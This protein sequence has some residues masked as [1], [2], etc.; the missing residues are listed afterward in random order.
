[1]K[2][3]EAE[4]RHVPRI[5]I[6]TL[7]DPI[8]PSQKYTL[9][10]YL[11]PGHNIDENARPGLLIRGSYPDTESAEA[12]VK[13]LPVKLDTV[14]VETGRVI[15]ACPT[16]EEMRTCPQRFE[17]PELNDLIAGMNSRNMSAE[18]QFKQH[19]D[20]SKNRKETREDLVGYI[21]TAE[22]QVND[23]RDYLALMKKRLYDY[24]RGEHRGT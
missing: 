20:E 5:H 6:D 21:T 10:S 12:A 18:T 15:P 2:N 11:V 17:E 3:R 14:V 9:V 8:S 16:K 23:G 1:L 22:K 7:E 4:M 24:D 19:C 13:T